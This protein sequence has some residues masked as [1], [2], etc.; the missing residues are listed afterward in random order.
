M[1][2][3]ESKRIN[4]QNNLEQVLSKVEDLTSN[5]YTKIGEVKS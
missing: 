3:L 4:F 5:Y 2:D 1:D